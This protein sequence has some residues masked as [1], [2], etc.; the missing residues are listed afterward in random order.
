M[1]DFGAV[2]EILKIGL[3]MGVLVDYLVIYGGFQSNS[4]TTL[5]VVGIK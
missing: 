5:V 1:R 3:Y 4:S 2:A